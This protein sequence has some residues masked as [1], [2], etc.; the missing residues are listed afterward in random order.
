MSFTTIQTS[1]RGPMYTTGNGAQIVGGTGTATIVQPVI[2]GGKTIISSQPSPTNGFAQQVVLDWAPSNA[3][4]TIDL[5]GTGLHTYNAMPSVA[6]ATRTVTWAT[7]PGTA[8]D[9]AWVTVQASR[10]DPSTQATTYWDWQISL[11][12][13]SSTFTYPLLP[14]GADKFNLVT[15]D[16]AS[17]AQL[18]TAKIP[19]GYDA[20][21]AE[22]LS[23]SGPETF[24]AGPTG[25]IQYEVLDNRVTFQETRS[26]WGPRRAAAALR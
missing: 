8:P 24:A 22:L 11:P 19:G 21:R 15:D 9:F 1:T 20:V 5:A 12:Y 10:T 13:T 17:V 4:V 6:P 23:S 16:V 25:R 14:A 7:D 26:S 2:A 3:T 18:L